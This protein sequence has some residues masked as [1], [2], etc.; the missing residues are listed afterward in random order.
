MELNLELSFKQERT[1][2][3]WLFQYFGVFGLLLSWEGGTGRQSKASKQL[4][5]WVGAKKCFL[6]LHSIFAGS[7]TSH[8]LSIKKLA[9][10]SFEISDLAKGWWSIKTRPQLMYKINFPLVSKTTKGNYWQYWESLSLALSFFCELWLTCL[11]LAHEKKEKSKGCC[12]PQYLA[13]YLLAYKAQLCLNWIECK[14]SSGMH[15]SLAGR[16]GPCIHSQSDFE[17]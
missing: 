1:L 13:S 10:R 4:I 3:V 9:S 12:C 2:A 8:T 14:Y 7:L 16:P 5:E 11:N 6:P 15:I 17:Y